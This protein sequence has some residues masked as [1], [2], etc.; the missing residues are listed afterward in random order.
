MIRRLRPYPTDAELAELYAAPNQSALWWEHDVRVD[1][2]IALGRRMFPTRDVVVD[3]STGDARIP[4]GLDPAFEPI[5]GDLAPGYPLVGPLEELVELLPHNYADIFVL[6]ET[7][8]HL[9]E[10][11]G[12]L[13]AI[14]RHARGLLLSTPADETAGNPEHVWAWSTDDIAELLETAGWTPTALVV[15]DLPGSYASKCQIWT[16]DAK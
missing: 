7:L 13:H 14:R 8:E 4:R 9:A 12:A 3:L 5:L 16:A 11:L 1:L 15:V 10:P 2:T 6:S